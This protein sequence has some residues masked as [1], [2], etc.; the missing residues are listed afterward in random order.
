MIVIGKENADD[1]LPLGVLAVAKVSLDEITTKVAVH[2]V[3]G[4]PRDVAGVTIGIDLHVNV[5]ASGVGSTSP[6]GKQG[7][8][9]FDQDP[10]RLL[11]VSAKLD[12]GVRQGPDH[13]QARCIGR[14][15]HDG[16]EKKKSQGDDFHAVHAKLHLITVQIEDVSHAPE[17][18]AMG[19][20]Q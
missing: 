8:V 9:A 11:R 18:L 16:M 4:P 19:I 15:N 17:K 5:P 10:D 20:K 13:F 2:A 6:S 7:E 3:I 14:S 12:G 1:M